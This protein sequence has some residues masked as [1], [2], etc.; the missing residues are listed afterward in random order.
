MRIHTSL[1]AGV[2][3]SAWIGAADAAWVIIDGS[4]KDEITY[5]DPAHVRLEGTKAFYWLMSSYSSPRFLGGKW[6]QSE[7]TQSVV[8]CEKQLLATFFFVGYVGPNATG[9]TTYTIIIPEQQLQFHP[10]VPNSIGDRELEAACSIWVREHQ[11][12]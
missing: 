7:I 9:E 11:G 12:K 1:I 6:S 4:Y 8:D 3:L 10:V 5:F 2:A